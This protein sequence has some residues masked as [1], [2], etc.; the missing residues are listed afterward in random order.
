MKQI[1]I[2]L[3]TEVQYFSEGCTSVVN[4]TP[5]FLVYFNRDVLPEG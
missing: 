2:P 5:V 4:V 1:Y 3:T